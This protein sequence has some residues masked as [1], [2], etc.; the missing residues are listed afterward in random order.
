MKGGSEGERTGGQGRGGK[1]KERDDLPYGLGD[2]E[3]ASLA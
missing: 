3:M 1:G 2:L